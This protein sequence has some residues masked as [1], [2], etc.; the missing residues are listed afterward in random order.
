M[1]SDLG[2]LP[3]TRSSIFSTANIVMRYLPFSLNPGVEASSRDA[4]VLDDSTLEENPV[5][6]VA[7][8]STRIV[9]KIRIF[10]NA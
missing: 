5:L 3:I 2:N 6:L 10:V 4:N 9:L 7:V 8:P 1:T